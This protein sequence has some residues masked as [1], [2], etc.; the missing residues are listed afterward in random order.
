MRGGIVTVVDVH[1]ARRCISLWGVVPVGLGDGVGDCHDAALRQR[2]G[3]FYFPF[4]LSKG[5]KLCFIKGMV[6]FCCIFQSML[7]TDREPNPGC[8]DAYSVGTLSGHFWGKAGR[9]TVSFLPW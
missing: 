8:N 6:Y 1:P 5:E 9:N 3:L 4:N 2:R 7:V